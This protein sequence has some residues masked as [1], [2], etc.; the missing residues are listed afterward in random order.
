MVA[1]RARVQDV[2]DVQLAVV[3]HELHELHTGECRFSFL[4]QREKPRLV[5]AACGLGICS[6][7]RDFGF[8]LSE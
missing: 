1:S 2:Q 4:R 5:S 3:L 6:G 7:K 8:Q